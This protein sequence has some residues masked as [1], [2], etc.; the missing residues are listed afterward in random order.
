ML[1]ICLLQA[2]DWQ[3]WEA[4]AHLAC[5]LFSFAAIVWWGFLVLV[6]PL[7]LVLDQPR[8]FFFCAILNIQVVL[9]IQSWAFQVFTIL[10]R[11]TSCVA[12][13]SFSQSR[14]HLR[15]VGLRKTQSLRMSTRRPVWTEQS[16]FSFLKTGKNILKLLKTNKT[17]MRS[18]NDR[19]WSPGDFREMSS[20]CRATKLLWFLGTN[21]NVIGARNDTLSIFKP[22]AEMSCWSFVGC[23]HVNLNFKLNFASNPHTRTD[24]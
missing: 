12:Q 22:R 20:S 3:Q 19:N 11:R 8:S 7:S 16:Y 4:H 5:N 21:Q 24:W 23:F 9:V 14:I 17:T 10:W 2:F 13:T 15:K 6:S 18:K 1:S